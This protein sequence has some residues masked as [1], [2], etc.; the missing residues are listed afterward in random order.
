MADELAEERGHVLARLV[1]GRRNDVRRLLVR[2]LQDPLTEVRL[3]R[4]DA[5]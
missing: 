1:D 3:Y 2:E 4:G 5:L